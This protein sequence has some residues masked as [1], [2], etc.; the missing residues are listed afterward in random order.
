[1]WGTDPFARGSYSSIGVGGSKADCD[2][3]CR[4]PIGWLS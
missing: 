3:P 2:L 4:A 1:M